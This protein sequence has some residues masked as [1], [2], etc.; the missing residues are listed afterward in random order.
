LTVTIADV[1]GRA[2][3]GVA[4]VSRVLNGSPSVSEETRSRVRAVIDELGY[5]PSAAARALSTGRTRTVGVVTPF[6][7]SPSVVER[8]RGVSRTVSEGGYQLVLFDLARPDRLARLPVGGRIDGLLCVSMCPSD[9]DLARLLKAGVAVALVDDEHPELPCVSIDDMAGGRLAAEHLLEL[10][11][12][13]IAFV[14]DDEGS[15]WGFRSSAR[16]RVG[17]EAALADAGG[18]LIVRRGPHGREHARAL[19]ARLLALDDPPTAI[20]A[21]SDLQAIGVLEAA[22]AAGIDVPDE[23]SV[24]GFDDVEL[25]RYVGLT[26]VSQPLESSGAAGA[27]LLMEAMGGAPRRACRLELRIVRRSTTASRGRS[28]D[29]RSQKAPARGRR[30]FRAGMASA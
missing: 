10:G 27:E 24:I 2:G 12:R 18:R 14:G 29:G 6:F 11:H 3:V 16:R 28:A 20:F 21:G 8:L 19:A 26:T 4:T 9:A 15:A 5:E 17:A 1:A 25:A 22:E 7:T 23:L 13:R 30:A